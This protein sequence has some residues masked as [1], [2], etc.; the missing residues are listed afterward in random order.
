MGQGGRN[1]F[2][3]TYV[4]RSQYM[5]RRSHSW[6]NDHSYERPFPSELDG[7]FC[8]N[9]KKE[10]AALRW[11]LPKSDLEGT[12]ILSGKKKGPN[13]PRATPRR[14]R[15]QLEYQHQDEGFPLRSSD[16]WS[17][18]YKFRQQGEDTQLLDGWSWVMDTTQKWKTT[19]SLNHRGSSVK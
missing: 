17:L 3:V 9:T 8:C 5:Q 1:P 6:R 4:L 7:P 13:F 15:C 11:L 18:A 19:C 16:I 2:W 12:Q 14:G 10:K